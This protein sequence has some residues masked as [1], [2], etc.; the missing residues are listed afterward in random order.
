M[1]RASLD[2]NLHL[3]KATGWLLLGGSAA[4]VFNA[5]QLPSLHITICIFLVAAISGLISLQTS[6]LSLLPRF[7]VLVYVMPFS[8]TVGYLFD[9]SYV[10]WES[11]AAIGLCQNHDIINQMLAIGFVGLCGLLG[12]MEVGALWWKPQGPPRNS[13]NSGTV[14]SARTMNIWPFAALLMAAV[15]LSWLYAPEKT[16]L[17]AAYASADAGGNAAEAMNFNA[18][19][20]VSYILLILLYLDGERERTITQRTSMKVLA[21]YATTGFIVIVL[22]LMRGDRE[23]SGLVVG[24]AM[25][26]LTKPGLDTEWLRA[27]ILQRKMFFRISFLLLF[28]FLVYAAVGSWRYSASESKVGGFANAYDILFDGLRQN[29]WTSVALNN[30]GMAAEYHS[31]TI[32][33]LHG[34]TYLDYFLSLPPGPIASALGYVR[35]LES[36]RGPNFWYAGL[37]SGGMHPA[38]VPF[39]NFG[40]TG[41]LLV[42]ALFGAFLSRCECRAN[43][44]A[45]SSRL[46]YGATAVSGFMWFWYGDMNIIRALMIGLVLY[47]VYQT[48]LMSRYNRGGYRMR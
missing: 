27:R 26:Y 36:D 45:L 25:V 47:L 10:F 11:R 42:L 8:A 38:V 7:F 31:G 33:Y 39:K 37:S 22:Q 48:C 28:L 30:L 19:F 44:G 5:E 14:G 34:Q 18:S 21:V 2:T 29:T 41:V 17:S 46:M 15:F 40:I 12:G 6:T 20:L 23:S 4:I 43:T 13:R 16:V 9:S 3:L 32:E 35:P 24:L 1:S